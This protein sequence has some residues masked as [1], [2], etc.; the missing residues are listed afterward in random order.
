MVQPRRNFLKLAALLAARSLPAQQEEDDANG[1]KIAHRLTWKGLTDDDLLFLQ[2]IGLKWAR[3][4]FGEGED[5]SVDALRAVQQRFARF[6][7][8][9]FSGV[10]YSYRTTR[11][12]LGQPGRDKDI[13]TYQQF[14]RNIG[15]LEIPVASYDFHPANTYTTKMV[16]R[17]GYTT[18]EFDVEDFRNKMDKPAFDR[19]YSADDIWT[20]YTYF[21]KAVLPVA[22]EAHVKLALHPDDPPLAKMNGVAKLFTHYDGYHRAE[23]ISA[24]SPW[25]GLTFCAGTWSEGGDKMGKSVIEMIR[26]FGGRGKIFE[27]HFRNVTGPLPH[28]VETFPDDGYMDMYQVMKALRQAKFTGAVEPDHVP[29]LAGDTGIL[30]AGSAYSISYIKALVRRAN[31]EGK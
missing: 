19:E 5:T 9:I 10:H 24:G 28:F 18:R 11:L 16:H 6:G 26:D 15:K 2:Q 17:R 25:W 1:I 30:R 21:M 29:K 27:V 3:V 8:K 12:Q 23:Q 22:A 20:T 7:M 4:E 13:E 14:L 31:E